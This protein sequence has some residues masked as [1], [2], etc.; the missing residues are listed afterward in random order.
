MEKGKVA[1]VM[2]KD[3]LNDRRVKR[4]PEELKGA[5]YPQYCDGD[6]EVCDVSFP[7]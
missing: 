5:S 2:L 1:A 6:I 7:D 4:H 3:L